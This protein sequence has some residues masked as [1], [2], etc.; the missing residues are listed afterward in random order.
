LVEGLADKDGSIRI[1]GGLLS[2][3]KGAQG[4]IFRSLEHVGFWETAKHEEKQLLFE[5]FS[6]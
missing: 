3:S 5:T 6:T 2:Q 1:E 4:V